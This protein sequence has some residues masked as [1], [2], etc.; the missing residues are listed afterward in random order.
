MQFNIAF[1]NVDEDFGFQTQLLFH[2]YI[3]LRLS[4]LLGTMA[5]GGTS[6]SAIGKTG[7]CV[8]R[9]SLYLP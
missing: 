1:L 4:P 7:L 8:V 9:T 3:Y 5:D 2:L 6:W